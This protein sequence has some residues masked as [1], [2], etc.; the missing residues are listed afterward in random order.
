MQ[1][2]LDALSEYAAGA[3]HGQQQLKQ[4]RQGAERQPPRKQQALC[5]HDGPVS[6]LDFRL[7]VRKTVDVMRQAA[8]L[9]SRSMLS[10]AHSCRYSNGAEGDARTCRPEK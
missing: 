7:E 6:L 9:R 3:T 10:F 2:Q 4:N 5:P 8:G 1:A